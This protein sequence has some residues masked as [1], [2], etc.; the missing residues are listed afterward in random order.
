LFCDDGDEPLHWGTINATLPAGT[1][2]DQWRDYIIKNGQQAGLSVGHVD[3]DPNGGILNP[4]PLVLFGMTVDEAQSYAAA[5]RQSWTVQGG[6]IQ[7][8]G[9]NSYR[10]GDI[11][12]N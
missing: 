11:G 6:K 8:V 3:H 4:R 5:T 10:P 12:Q 9:W 1:T 7:I 2:N